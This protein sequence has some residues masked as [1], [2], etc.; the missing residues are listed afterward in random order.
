[1]HIYVSLF[2]STLFLATFLYTPIVAL[3]M[4]LPLYF[5]YHDCARGKIVPTAATFFDF[6][7]FVLI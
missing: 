4:P 2:S 1:M 3:S 5:W 6:L 7:D